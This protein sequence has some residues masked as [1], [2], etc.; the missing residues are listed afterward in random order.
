M[1]ESSLALDVAFRRR[2]RAWHGI[3]RQ[4]EP[5]GRRPSRPK[6]D[7]LL[8]GI[9]L[10]LTALTSACG[11]FSVADDRSDLLAWDADAASVRMRPV[12]DEDFEL[13]RRFPNLKNV[14]VCTGRM[15]HDVGSTSDGWRRLA[16]IDPP[17]LTSVRACFDRHLDDETLRQ[18]ARLNGLQA[19]SIYGCPGFTQEGLSAILSLPKLSF[20]DVRGCTQI[21]DTWLDLIL[22][23]DDLGSLYVSGTSMSDAGFARLRKEMR[24]LVQDD[25]RYWTFELHSGRPAHY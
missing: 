23:R 4:G 20:L 16:E 14:D 18:I 9:A 24:G 12:V 11:N 25:P 5:R 2:R 6:V 21:D 10:I 13:L 17:N 15:A 7:A 19:V 3:L 1:T 8:T 22:S